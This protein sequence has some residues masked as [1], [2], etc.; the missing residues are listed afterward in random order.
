ME[1]KKDKGNTAVPEVSQWWINWK[2]KQHLHFWKQRVTNKLKGSPNTRKNRQ[3]RGSTAHYSCPQKKWKISKQQESNPDREQGLV[4]YRPWQKKTHIRKGLLN[5]GIQKEKQS[6]FRIST[7]LGQDL[8]CSANWKPGPTLPL[9]EPSD[10]AFLNTLTAA[11]CSAPSWAQHLK[12]L[13]PGCATEAHLNSEAH[14]HRDSQN[15]STVWTASNTHR[16]WLSLLFLNQRKAQ[17]QWG[18]VKNEVTT[19]VST[20]LAAHKMPL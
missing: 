12:G 10:P 4:F 2:T 6:S 19:S 20:R 14:I 9:E 17:T 13:A 8:T 16:L 1:K 3:Q 7:F 11:L 5:A 18:L 15:K